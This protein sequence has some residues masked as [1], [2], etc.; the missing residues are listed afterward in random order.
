MGEFETNSEGTDLWMCLIIALEELYQLSKE[1]L[2]KM[3][4]KA[5]GLP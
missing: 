5:K 2:L 3:L 1:E 4:K